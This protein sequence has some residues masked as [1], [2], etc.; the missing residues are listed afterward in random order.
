MS[1]GSNLHLLP[2]L[3]V[4]DHAPAAVKEAFRRWSGLPG[5]EPI[6]GKTDFRVSGFAPEHEYHP[7]KARLPRVASPH[8][9]LLRTEDNLSFVAKVC[10][11]FARLGF[12][13][14]VDE[15]PDSRALDYASAANASSGKWWTPAVPRL[16]HSLANYGAHWG[17][18]F[19][20]MSTDTHILDIL[21]LEVGRRRVLML[22]IL[23]GRNPLF[24]GNDPDELV[25]RDQ[26]SLR[27][28]FILN[29]SPELFGRI[30]ELELDRWP[31]HKGAIESIWEKFEAL[32]RA[33]SRPIGQ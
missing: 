17:Y 26:I 3:S 29:H 14:G 31:A 25:I 11:R 22:A 28:I 2:E 18:H 16:A 27:R 15:D 8:G 30:L 10:A 12:R 1:T 4:K 13:N 32:E 33:V 21:G 20:T 19:S 9:L 24:R 6:L 23:P 7:I 5:S